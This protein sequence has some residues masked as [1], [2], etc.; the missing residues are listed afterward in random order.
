MD[1]DPKQGPKFVER[2]R[3]NTRRYVH[4]LVEEN[5]TLRQ[6]LEVLESHKHVLESWVKNLESALE[7][8]REEREKLLSRIDALEKIRA[9][10]AEEY[11]MVEQENNHLAHLY[12]ATFSLHGTLD[13][14]KVLGVIQ[15]IVINL[16]GS[17]EVAIFELDAEG[18]LELASCF[19]VDVDRLNGLT[20][21]NGLIARTVKSGLLYLREDGDSEGG[22]PGVSQLTTCVP[23][24]IEGR[25]SGVIAVFKL[26]EQKQG[27][28]PLDLELLDLLGN[29]AAIALHCASLHARWA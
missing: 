20:V 9:S 15:E 24:K 23:L 3:E 12:S 11:A 17:E 10:A 18:R 16:I 8:E 5:A 13:R 27:L 25:V 4:A 1:G 7:N 29:Q 6:K 21:E 14:E 2:V 19:G 28:E 22:G 26:L